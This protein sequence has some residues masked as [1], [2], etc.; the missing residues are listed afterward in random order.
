MKKEILEEMLKNISGNVTLVLRQLQSGDMY[1]S[2]QAT[3][4]VNK[5]KIILKR[6]FIKVPVNG[7]IYGNNSMNGDLLIPYEEICSVLIQK[8]S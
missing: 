4:T 2:S 7:P 3:I 5:N 6:N 8:K 1:S